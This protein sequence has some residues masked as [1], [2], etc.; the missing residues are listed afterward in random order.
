MTNN[1]LIIKLKKDM[2]MR[3]FSKY[4]INHDK[5][6]EVSLKLGIATDTMD[7][8][9]KV[10][11]ERKVDNAILSKEHIEKVLFTFVGKQ[12]QEPPVYSVSP[13]ALYARRHR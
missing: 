10:L 4:L 6:Y 13:G 3:N 7:A 2:Q 8:E 5:E 1:Q 9:G 12:E 11:E